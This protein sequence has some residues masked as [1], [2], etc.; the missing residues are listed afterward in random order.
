MTVARGVDAGILATN[1]PGQ[2]AVSPALVKP[3]REL[4]AYVADRS[5][6]ARAVASRRT[7]RALAPLPWRTRMVPRRESTSL[8]WRAR[9]SPTRRPLR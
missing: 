9:A 5:T 2:E 4:A 7:V 6:T 1:C 8:G 3:L